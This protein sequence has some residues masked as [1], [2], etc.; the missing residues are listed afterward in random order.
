MTEIDFEKLNGLV[1]A[2]IQDAITH[3]VL[4]LG[5]M[6]KEAYEKTLESKKVTF[7]SR[8]CNCLWT[9]G[10]TSGNYLNVVSIKNDCDND[11]LLIMVH[12]Q[13]PT[14]HKG[15]DT[16]WGEDN[17]ANPLL[18]LTELQDFIEKRHEEMPE[19]SYTTSLFKDGLNRMAQKVG[20]EALEAVIEA[21]NGEDS[22]L[23][24]ESADMFY[25]LIVLLTSKGLRIEDIAKELQVRHDPNWHK[26]D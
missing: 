23:I 9:K 3:K 6:N 21:T 7:W 22:R 4:M 15:T 17:N 14:C 16:C 2:I 24:Y 8:T 19:G 11:T 26:H 20:E 12:P 1:P 10:E 18:F 5:F 13:G 25:H